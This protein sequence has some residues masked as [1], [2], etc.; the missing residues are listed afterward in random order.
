MKPLFV[1]NYRKIESSRGFVGCEMD[2]VHPQYVYSFLGGLPG[3]AEVGKG[4]SNRRQKGMGGNYLGAR[5][6]YQHQFQLNL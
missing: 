2:F 6:K 5:I 1:G 4:G 3:L